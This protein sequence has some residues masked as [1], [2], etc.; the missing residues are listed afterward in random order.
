MYAE[1]E[2]VYAKVIFTVMF[3]MEHCKKFMIIYRDSCNILGGAC[4]ESV[5]R[6]A[7]LDF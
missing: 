2:T 5:T 7:K 4:L 1:Y 3:R 6:C